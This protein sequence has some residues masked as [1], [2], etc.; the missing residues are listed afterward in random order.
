MQR[1]VDGQ[2]NEEEFLV[3]Q[4]GQKISEDITNKG[5]IKSE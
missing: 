1:L 4:P 2:W 3:V 5:I